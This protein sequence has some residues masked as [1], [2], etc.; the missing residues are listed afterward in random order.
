MRRGESLIFDEQRLVLNRNGGPEESF[1]RLTYSPVP[2]GMPCDTASAAVAGGVLVTVN[3]TTDLVH[4]RAREAE[5]IQLK[6]AMQAKRIGL[7][8]EI[9]RNAPSFLYVLQGPELVF[10]FV[11]DAFYKLVGHREL[12]G[13]PAFEA[14][15]ELAGCGAKENLVKVMTTGKPFT[16][17]ELPVTVVRKPGEPPEERL[18]D[19]IYLPLFDEEGARQR[20]LGHGIDVT[21]HVQERKDAEEALR[22]SEERFRRALELDTVGFVFFNRKG[23]VTEANDAF[24]KMSGLN[25]DDR[26]SGLLQCNVETPSEWT[27]VFLRAVGDFGAAD[28]TT[29]HEQEFLRTDSSHWWASIT[30]KQLDEREAIAYVTDI[31]ERKHAEQALRES[32]AR[33]RA[34]SEASPA[35]TWQVDA[36]GNVVYLNQRYMDMVGMNL[37][38]LMPSGW[39]SILHPEDA[40]AYLAAFEQ[41]TTRMLPLSASG[42]HKDGKKRMALAEILCSAVVY[43]RGRIRWARRHVCRYYRGRKRGNSPAGS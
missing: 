36:H 33:F 35:I 31:T 21:T 37:E 29:P 3:E 27:E 20:V 14:L 30:A 41:A 15:P 34:I 38:Q 8:E 18:V 23:E 43:R 26:R 9:F 28:S 2:G 11:N 10:E 42:S 17:F 4:A 19:V 1:F 13:R 25:R 32:E 40:P 7:L 16:G 39:R 24:L 12:I 5:R 6:E 22:A